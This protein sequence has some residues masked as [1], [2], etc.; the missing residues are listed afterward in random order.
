MN[1]DGHSLCVAF[2][3]V[4]RFYRLLINKIKQYSEFYIKNC[5][6]IQYSHG[7]QMLAVCAGKNNN[8]VLTVIHTL[9]MK[10]V[11]N[12]KIGFTAKQIVWN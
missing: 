5:Y 9:K 6:L 7:G 1:P 4:I 11:C 2:P 8:A 3:D 10:E 12:F